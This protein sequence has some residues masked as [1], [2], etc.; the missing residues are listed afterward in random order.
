MDSSDSAMTARSPQVPRCLGG[1]Y[2]LLSL[3]GR[4]GHGEVYCA[5][6]R[7]TDDLVA[8][9]VVEP[10]GCPVGP[11]ARREIAALRSVQLPG[12]VRF[13]DEGADGRDVFLVMELVPGRPFPG[14]AVPAAW[15]DLAETTRSLLEILAGVHAAGVVHQD[16]TPTNVLVHEGR[17]TLLDF[18]VA[19]SGLDDEARRG[20]RS[21]TPAYMAPEQVEGAPVSSATDLFALGCVLFEALAGRPPFESDSAD[22]Q[23]SLRCRG[24]APPLRALVPDAPSHVADLV[25]AMLQRDPR[26]RPSDAREALARLDGRPSQVDALSSSA[27]PP[28][29]LDELRAMIIGPDRIFHVPEDGAAVIWARTGGE[30]SRVRA[31]VEAWVRVGLA[32]RDGD[33]VVLNRATVDRLAQPEPTLALPPVAADDPAAVAY[34][35]AHA[36]AAAA[37]A[38][39]PGAPGRLGHLVLA[40]PASPADALS[41]VVAEGVALARRALAEGRTGAGLAAVAEAWLTAR[42]VGERVTPTVLRE[43]FAAWTELALVDATPA[44]IDRAL[45]ELDLAQDFGRF[46]DLTRL[47]R[48]AVVVHC[49]PARAFEEASALPVLAEPALERWRHAVRAQAARFGPLDRERALVES[50][51]PWAMSS[52]DPA[53]HAAF[54][55]WEA[56]TLYRDGRYV[57][58]SDRHLTAAALE[59]LPASRLASLL[60][61]ASALLEA[62]LPE[63]ARSLA[64]SARAVAAASRLPYLE[65]RACWIERASDYRLHRPMEPDEGLV[66][67]VKSVGVGSLHALVAMTEAAIAWRA[68]DLPTARALAMEAFRQWSSAGRRWAPDMARA[69]ALACGA[70]PQPGEVDLMAAEAR[71]CPVPA[72]GLQVLALLALAGVDAPPVAAHD[73]A[74]LAALVPAADHARRGAILSTYEALEH[75]RVAGAVTA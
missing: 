43:A 5:R 23:M 10:S 11:Q 66:A 18:G 39:P 58:A 72:A 38:L 28:W 65:A 8:V 71:R 44:A 59:S 42:R 62:W 21:G 61:A 3:I 16:I 70:R 9:K 6:D 35:R 64:V 47:L 55:G 19:W 74:R 68:A 33:R 31:L 32:R 73:V 17:P 60:A 63:R 40:L 20:G 51:R 69:L 67:A 53:D 36:H 45:H 50:L 2:S 15:A 34:A 27:G 4:G 41:D 46:A 7:I 54:A 52:R 57:E 75:L 56:W 12:V 22:E 26:R 14:C 37:A 49:S 30:R 25:D 24:E 48:A 1:R 29:T 13:L